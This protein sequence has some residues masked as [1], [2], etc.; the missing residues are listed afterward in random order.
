MTGSIIDASRLQ[1]LLVRI[2]GLGLTLISVTLIDT[3]NAQA[4]T[5]E[6]RSTESNQS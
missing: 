6:V 1:G 4:A 5:S 3:E 2:T